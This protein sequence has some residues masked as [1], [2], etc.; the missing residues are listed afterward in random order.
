[1]NSVVIMPLFHLKKFWWVSVMDQSLA[2]LAA[3]ISGW[4]LREWTA[5]TTVCP[6]CTCQCLC[7]TVEASSGISW[8]GILLALVVLA[9][10]ALAFVWFRGP[11]QSSS[12]PQKG[13]KGVFGVAGKAVP[14]KY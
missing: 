2:G 10:G 8:V 5:P 14:I 12:S 9:V 3:A 13:T 11:S 1:M 6:P 4:C 7:E